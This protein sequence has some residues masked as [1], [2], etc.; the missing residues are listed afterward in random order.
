VD[1]TGLA[2]GARVP[3]GIRP[4]G[5]KL[6][7]GRGEGSR[8]GKGVVGSVVSDGVAVTVA[9]EWAGF[10]LRTHLLAG[11]GL[12]RTACPG[13]AVTLSVRPED[14]HLLPASSAPAVGASL[15]LAPPAPS[16]RR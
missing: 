14:V 1:E 15:S 6:D 5:L 7:V 10:E 11:R 2:P 12:A 13:D 8:I 4:E 16:A 9:V 3:A